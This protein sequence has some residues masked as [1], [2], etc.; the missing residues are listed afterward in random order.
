MTSPATEFDPEKFYLGKLCPRGHDWNGTGR[1]LRY[2]S[3]TICTECAK[4]NSERYRERRKE[5]RTRLAEI[6]KQKTRERN[7]EKSRERARRR[8]ADDPEKAR[9]NSRRRYAAHPEVYKTYNH[10]RRACK[11]AALVIPYTAAELASHFAQFDGCAYC[12]APEQTLDHFF[13]LSHDLLAADALINVVPACRRC[14]SS[15]NN[16]HP[17]QWYRA[18]PFYDPARLQRIIDALG[19]GEL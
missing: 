5:E 7:R 19:I 13:P 9:E 3:N 17:V 14:N 10:R 15:K 4:K 12:G 1:S 8:R 11:A 2:R 6:S 16:R 18:Q